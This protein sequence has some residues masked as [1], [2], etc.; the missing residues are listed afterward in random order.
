MQFLQPEHHHHVV[1]FHA[2]SR[3][4]LP[5]F[6]ASLDILPHFHG[7]LEPFFS[8]SLLILEPQVFSQLSCLDTEKFDWDKKKD[9]YPHFG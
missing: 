4:G 6:R 7:L 8:M 3:D 9:G 5:G 1:R 2:V